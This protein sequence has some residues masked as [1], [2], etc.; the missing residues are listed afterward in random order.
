MR[1]EDR[2]A[3]LRGAA[4]LAGRKAPIVLDRL[5]G[6]AG[7]LLMLWGMVGAVAIGGLLR[8][9]QRGE[10]AIVMG[11]LAAGGILSL[12]WGLG[13][14]ALSIS[15]KKKAGYAFRR[16]MEIAD[17]LSGADRGR[18]GRELARCGLGAFGSLAAGFLWD[19]GAE[20]VAWAKRIPGRAERLRRACEEAGAPDRARSQAKRLD[21]SAL[22]AKSD[23]GGRREGL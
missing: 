1:R 17:P 11:G 14:I 10:S 8:G 3:L 21:A 19:A 22:S 18:A 13:E 12:A 2:Y 6:M 23:R 4:R 15:G 20:L 9:L 16:F 5:L 7:V